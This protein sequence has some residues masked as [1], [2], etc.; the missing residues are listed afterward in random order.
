M[1]PLT[2][3]VLNLAIVLLL[4]TGALRVNS[5][6]LSQGQL[7][8]LYNYM[9]QILV[10][11]VKLANLIVTLTKSAACARRIAGTLAVS[12][13]QQDGTRQLAAEDLRLPDLPGCGHRLLCLRRRG[14][15]AHLL[16]RPPRAD[17]RHHRGNRLRKVHAGEPDSPVL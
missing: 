5:G 7:I 13:S 6:T 16:H 8:A 4:H 9:S 1:N 17:H 12:S 14:A 15:G 2:F 11:L 3:L 10:E